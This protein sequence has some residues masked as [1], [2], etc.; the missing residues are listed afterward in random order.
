MTDLCLLPSLCHFS[1][2]EAEYRLPEIRPIY[3]QALLLHL[4]SE[5]KESN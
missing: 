1:N 3:P 5:D 2:S 4:A